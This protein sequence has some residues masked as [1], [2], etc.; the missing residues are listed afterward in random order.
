MLI[1]PTTTPVSSVN[2]D[3]RAWPECQR[4]AAVPVTIPILYILFSWT[5]LLSNIFTDKLSTASNQPI[6]IYNSNE[7]HLLGK[8]SGADYFQSAN[9]ENV[10][11]NKYFH[12]PYWFLHTEVKSI[13]FKR[14][15]LDMTWEVATGLMVVGIRVMIRKSSIIH[16]KQRT[17][18]M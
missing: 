10:Q 9:W 12:H 14:S 5:L 4:H 18:Q 15:I 13:T 3:L 1:I 7:E 6:V 8:R 2:I 16:H 11:A 17:W